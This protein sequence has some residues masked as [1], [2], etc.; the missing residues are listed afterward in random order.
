[1]PTNDS[2]RLNEDQ[3]ALPSRPKAPQDHPEQLVRSGKSRLP[4]PLFQDVQPLPQ[5]QVFQ[6]Q[7]AARANE[8]GK[9]GTSLLRLTIAFLAVAFATSVV[10]AH[11]PTTLSQPNDA[12]HIAGLPEVRTN[13]K[14]SLTLTLEALVFTTKDTS[15]PLP[16][17]RIVNVFIGDQRTL[18]GGTKGMVV[19][20]AIP[21]AFIAA[22]A[23][24]GPL[25]VAGGGAAVGALTN[26]KVDLLTVEFIDA[27]DGY[28]GV[29][30]Q[31][32]SQQAARIRDQLVGTV[33]APMERQ[34]PVCTDASAQPRSV[35]L[36]PVAISGVG[37]PA[38]Y[39]V[40]LY[41]QLVK[42]L[43]AKRLDATFLRA[44]DL[45][46]GAGCT[47]LT[48]RIT[49]DDFKKDNRAART[50]A[51]PL[52]FFLGTTSLSFNVNLQDSRG[53]TIFAKQIKKSKR[54][55]S[56]SLGIANSIAK[57]VAKQLDQ[58]LQKLPLQA[59][60]LP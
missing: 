8:L 24:V 28:H 50:S 47:A 40:L 5:C 12:I 33:T 37:L 55:D 51:G 23:I 26:K 54:G 14:G 49:V 13:L 11:N 59:E 29:V 36:A 39:W 9:G 60:K 35:L 18:R 30:F 57:D 58:A 10:R 1:M 34:A 15:E 56:D 53:A 16:R 3:N 19:R 38:E 48:L 4:A 27:Q 41:E 32:P 52:G 6:E 21:L 46:A 17:A 45:A 42:Q 22:G 2:L 7:V 20:Q 25:A 44:G 43:K 31:L